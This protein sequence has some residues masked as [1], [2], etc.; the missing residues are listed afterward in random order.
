MNKP[1]R[2]PGRRPKGDRA[3]ICAKLP[4]DHLAYYRQAAEDLDIPVGDY[5]A[6]KLAEVHG[7][8]VPDYITIN[9]SQEELPISA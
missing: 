3:A 6:L 4:V 2:S 8:P 7:W 5:I 9:R 1:P